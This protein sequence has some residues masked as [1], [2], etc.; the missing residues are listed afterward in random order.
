M[1]RKQQWML[2]GAIVAVAGIALYV[3]TLTLDETHINMVGSRAPNSSAFTLDEPPATRTLD[4]YKGRVILLNV[5]ATWCGPCRIEI[6][7]LIEISKEF[8]S[9]GVEVLGLTTEEKS[10]VAAEV[11]DFVKNFEIPYAVGWANPQIQRAV[12]GN[13][14][15]IPQSI[16][17]GKDGKILA[18]NTMVKAADDSKA[19]LELVSK[20]KQ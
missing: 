17:I 20:A 6:P 16:I 2:V 7:H 10:E 8:K 15:S 1:T 5:W 14:P 3:A 18:K 9:K 13:A 4:E 12:L 19:I 11:D